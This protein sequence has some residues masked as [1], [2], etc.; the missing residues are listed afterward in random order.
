MPWRRDT[1]NGVVLR[2]KTTSILTGGLQIPMEGHVDCTTSQRPTH[3]SFRVAQTLS[4]LEC[5]EKYVNKKKRNLT[6]VQCA[7][8]FP[9]VLA[10]CPDCAVDVFSLTTLLVPPSR[11]A[12]L[13]KTLGKVRRHEI[14]R[15]ETFGNARLFEK[16]S[17]V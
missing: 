9:A 11:A 15:S 17:Y 3:G 10:E 6:N 14:N 13:H 1:Y 5:D 7:I 12:Q 2:T 4:Q 8:I 16:K